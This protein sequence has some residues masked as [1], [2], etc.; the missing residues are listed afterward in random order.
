MNTEH[1]EIITYLQLPADLLEQVLQDVLLAVL[2]AVQLDG[3]D[4]GDLGVERVGVVAHHGEQ[5]LALASAHALV[6]RRPV[7][8]ELAGALKHFNKNN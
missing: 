1:I 7:D 2:A 4:E 3:G 5:V 8:A 6:D